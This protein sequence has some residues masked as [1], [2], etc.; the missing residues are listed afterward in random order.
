MRLGALDRVLDVGPVL[1]R[2][3]NAVAEALARWRWRR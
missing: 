1:D 2:S 3:L